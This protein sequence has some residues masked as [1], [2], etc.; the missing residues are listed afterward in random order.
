MFACSSGE[1]P[2]GL[3]CETSCQLV[4]IRIGHRRIAFLALKLLFQLSLRR[5]WRIDLAVSLCFKCY[6]ISCYWMGNR[7]MDLYVFFFK[8]RKTKKSIIIFIQGLKHH[9]D[10][11]S[12]L[13]LSKSDLHQINTYFWN[14][15]M[16]AEMPK[17][18]HAIMSSFSG[19]L[20]F[21]AK[22]RSL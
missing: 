4:R 22:S 2:S 14:G 16:N 9:F 12:N 11:L 15:W 3:R 20:T 19:L 7:R 17:Y 5:F 18:S 8:L 6:W 1:L 21:S 13:L 10:K